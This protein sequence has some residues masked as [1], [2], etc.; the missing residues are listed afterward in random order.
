MAL[1]KLTL[2]NDDFGRAVP[3]LRPRAGGARQGTASAASS[4]I[5]PFAGSV[6][7]ISIYAAGDIRYQTGGAAVEATAAS[8][9]LAAGERHVISLGTR[10]DVHT[11][12][13][14]IRAGAADVA[15][16]VSELE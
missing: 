13:A 8:H 16:D 2:P 3:V 4:I 10:G 15:V 1:Q 6:R 9:K 7:V 14:I 12:L 5:G 11:H